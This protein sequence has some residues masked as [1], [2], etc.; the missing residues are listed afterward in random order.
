MLT[1]WRQYE[2]A[3]SVVYG[4]PLKNNAD[5]FDLQAGDVSSNDVRLIGFYQINFFLFSPSAFSSPF[6]K[7]N[8]RKTVIIC[9]ILER[10]FVLHFSLNIS[11]QICIEGIQPCAT[12]CVVYV[13]VRNIYDIIQS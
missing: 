9:Y 6:T 13:G 2:V 4:T 3:S 1:Q 8:S 12:F 10:L 5:A 11:S 7:E